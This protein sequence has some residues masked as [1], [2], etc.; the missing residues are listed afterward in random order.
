M[1]MCLER[2]VGS[3]FWKF[4][5][6]CGGTSTG[7]IICLALSKGFTLQEVERMYLCMKNDVFKGSK[8]FCAGVFEDLL[9]SKFGQATMG[10]VISPKMMI[11]TAITSSAP[12]KLKF[13]RS[14]VP[15]LTNDE[16]MTDLDY[17]DPKTISMWKAARCSSAAPS[18]FT[19]FVDN[20]G[21]YRSHR[22]VI[23]LGCGV[24]RFVKVEESFTARFLS[25]ASSTLGFLFDNTEVIKRQV[26][27]KTPLFRFSPKLSNDVG[28]CENND[29]SLIEMMWD[30]EESLESS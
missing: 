5:D 12:A 22:S 25:Y 29:A 10:A 8:P 30:A 3:C 4:V 16:K 24:A 7:A 9:K 6:W 11:T 20:T 1:M 28:V 18:Y 2:M 21:T 15:L 26:S 23:S 17:D 14:Y 19:K 13:F 27:L